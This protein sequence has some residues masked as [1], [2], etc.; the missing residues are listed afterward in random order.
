MMNWVWFVLIGISVVFG[1]AT[2]HINE[3]SQ[4]SL[5][6][7]GNA[8]ALFIT[9]LGSMCLWNG[10]MK[11]ADACGITKALAAILSPITKRLFPDLAPTSAGMKAVS[12]NIAANFLGLGNAATPFGLC[13]M[14]EMAKHSHEKGVATDSMAMF[15]V[16]NTASLQL[17]PTTI[18]VIRMKYG[19]V[20]PFDILP[21][22]WLSSIVTLVSG[23]LLARI[24]ESRQY[25]MKRAPATPPG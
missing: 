12:M 15:I 10:L 25:R 17:I 14:K 24:F 4:A 5:N 11:I 18:A 13:A 22:V 19:S 2:G 21:C 16:M 3:V 7:A 6:G 9:L 23:I 1:I 8:V 20:A